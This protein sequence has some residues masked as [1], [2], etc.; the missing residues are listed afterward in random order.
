M[1]FRFA[2]DAGAG[3]SAALYEL[4][5]EAHELRRDGEPVAIQPKPLALLL[6]LVRERDRVVPLDELFEVLWPGV[7]V[8]PSSLTRAVSVARSAIGDTGRGDL[9]RSFARRGYRFCG[10]VI[11]IEPSAPEARADAPS[12]APEAPAARAADAA[13]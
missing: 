4:D 12:A 6:H 13:R 2:R 9:V 10:D 7:A 11:A 8:T 1:I 5:E 3:Q